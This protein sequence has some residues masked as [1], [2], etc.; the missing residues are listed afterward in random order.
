MNRLS[1]GFIANCFRLSRQKVKLRA[2]SA[3][4]MIVSTVAF[5]DRLVNMT[6]RDRFKK[7]ISCPFAKY[8]IVLRRRKRFSLFRICFKKCGMRRL[9]LK[10]RLG[11]KSL[12]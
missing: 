12:H 2:R 7:R 11:Q 4:S 8:W 10:M 9:L 1:D 6:S 5:V 3:V